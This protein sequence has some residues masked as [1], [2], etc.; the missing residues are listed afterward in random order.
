VIQRPLQLVNER[1]VLTDEPLPENLGV[2]L[3]LSADRIEGR[4]GAAAGARYRHFIGQ[5]LAA[6]PAGDRDD[7]LTLAALAA[8]RSGALAF[9]SDALRRLDLAL[10]AGSPTLPALA[11]A[12]G[13][14]EGGVAPFAELQARSRFGWPGRNT[15]GEILA[16]VGGFRG[17]FGPWLAPPV[18][19]LAGDQVGTF[20]IRTGTGSAGSAAGSSAAA[21]GEAMAED[22]LLTVDVFGHTLVR[23]AAEEGD[24]VDAADSAET[25]ARWAA[26]GDTASGLPEAGADGAVLRIH[27]YTAEVRLPGTA[28]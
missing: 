1:L 10:A 22:W 17:L 24:V 21:V 15:P 18:A 23:L 8:W 28:E 19:V 5:A 14:G 2:D 7:L 20:L 12:L 27:A 11:A 13:L 3:A 25:A 16:V 26:A 9:R 4:H 6:Q